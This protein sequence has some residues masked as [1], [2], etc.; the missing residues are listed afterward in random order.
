MM[1]ASAVSTARLMHAVRRMPAAP[2]ILSQLGE[3]LND[4][5]VELEDVC[6][7]LRRDAALTARVI[8]VS[9]SP[10][11]NTGQPFASMEEALARVGFAEVYRLTGFAA[12]A[13]LGDHDLRFY[14]VSGAQFRENSLLTAL[15][16]EALAPR[17]RLDARLTYTAGL[18]R[19]TGKVA[20]D[21][22][23][24]DPAYGGTY[25]SRGSGPLGTWEDGFI[26]VSNC[27]AAAI[28]LSEWR[29]PMEAVT[30]IREHYESGANV[31]R[32][33]ALLNLA[34]GA[35]ERG[36]TRM[37]G[38]SAYWVASPEKFSAAGVTGA[39]LQAAFER[40]MALFNALRAAMG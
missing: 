26:G 27:E 30:A 3:L 35:A 37:P 36:G 32:L 13:Q 34:A 6:R 18:L 4:P 10:I 24:K 31:S 8:R 17:A 29:F 12:V 23:A 15:V 19:S 5:N 21:H 9:N 2:Q 7:L 38:E 28:I 22:L 16:M 14:G 20:L 33:T 25:A 40:A 39:D 11:Y 1:I